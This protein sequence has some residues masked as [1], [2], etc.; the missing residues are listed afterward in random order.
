M[1]S[2][3]TAAYLATLNEKDRKH[4]LSQMTAQE[5]DVLYYDWNFWARPSQLLPNGE[6]STWLIQAG[7]GWGKLSD[8]NDDVRTIDGWK[9]LGDIVDGDIIFGADGNPCNVIK[10]HPIQEAENTYK[11]TFDTG[12][13]V[14]CGEEHLWYTE[15]KDEIS[16]GTGGKTRTTK[17]IVNTLKVEWGADNHGVPLAKPIQFTNNKLSIEPYT[18]GK[19]L[20]HKPIYQK[21]KKTTTTHNKF[22]PE[23]YMNTSIF[24]RFELLKGIM[25]ESGTIS[26]RGFCEISNR[27]LLD[28]IFE[29]ISSLGIKCWRYPSRKVKKDVGIR[30]ESAKITFKTDIPVFKNKNKLDMQ[31]GKLG[32]Y[33]HRFKY[34]FITDAVK[35]DNVKLRCLTVDSKDHLFLITKSFIPT[36]NTRVG[37]QSILAWKNMGYNRFALIA[38]TPADA[39]DV[40]IEGNSGILAISP[41]WD[42][43]LYESTKR[44]LTWNNGAVAII[45]SGANPEQLR[46]PQHD[47][48]WCDEI[49]AWQYPQETWDMLM[50]GLRL[51]DNPQSV[52]TSTPRPM[53]LIK[54][55]RADKGTYITQGSTYENKAN[56]APKF[57]AEILNKYEGSRL[58]RQELYA[59][60]LDDNPNALWS[61]IDIDACRV[62][63]VPPLKRIV[64]AIDPATTSKEKSDDTG[65]IVAGIGEDNHWYVLE[66]RSTKATP[67][68]WGTIA[69]DAYYKWNADRL[70]AEV[71]QGGDMVEHTIR[72]I[73]ANISFKK[74][75]ATKGKYTRAEPISALYEQHRV[76]HVGSLAKLEDQMCEWIPGMPSPDRVDACVWA[77]TELMGISRHVPIVIPD[78]EAGI[79]KWKTNYIVEE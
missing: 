11:L 69:I 39:R 42:K 36:H 27:V 48:A 73:D 23:Q 15:T 13:T 43:P 29:L 37:A 45:F 56:L 19:I 66:D 55:L 79:S 60:I 26:D 65:I 57:F 31:L 9:K 53:P 6:W 25:D 7:R 41:P 3:I 61:R 63:S 70:V 1:S 44:R 64:V 28:D 78:T 5:L 22:I 68:V 38:E 24:N 49:F 40:M 35:V 10:A 16:N 21:G 72:S 14:T 8:I 2:K 33:N 58:G 30:T 50:F 59:E 67:Q 17:E 34:R 77:I 4:I 74:V 71:N 76:H 75:H 52:V 18:F 12:E 51:G 20:G 47:K 62:Q 54:T 46:G 32:T